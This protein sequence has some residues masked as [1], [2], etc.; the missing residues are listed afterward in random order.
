[1]GPPA[2]LTNLSQLRRCAERQPPTIHPFRILANVIDANLAGK[3]LLLRDGSGTEFLRL[4]VPDRQIEPGAT[5]CLEGSGCGVKPKSFGLELVPGLVADDDGI[6]SMLEKSG[7]VFL[8]EGANPITVQW[9]N[10]TRDFGLS[11][12][13][14]GPG[15]PRQPVRVPLFRQSALTLLPEAPILPLDL[16]IAV[17]KAPGHTSRI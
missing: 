16:T 9:F 13:Y 15:L 17:T 14:E 2:L 6:H 3:V 7:T 1:M 11:V 4:D 5:V 10:R 8:R 12:E